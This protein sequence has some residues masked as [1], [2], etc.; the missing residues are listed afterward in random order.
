MEVIRPVRRSRTPSW[1]GVCMNLVLTAWIMN[2]VFY[3]FILLYT[4]YYPFREIWAAIPGVWLQQ[5]ARAALPSPTGACWVFLC[6]RNAPNSDVDYRIFNVRTWPFLCV[7]IHTRRGWAHRQRVD[8]TFLTEK[9]TNFSCA[10]DGVRTSGLW[11][12]SP[13]LYRLSH[14][15]HPIFGFCLHARPNVA[16]YCTLLCL[17]VSC[18]CL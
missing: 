11:I 14:P 7:R 2:N 6:F 5:A 8:T 18:V 12:S 1:V 3:L 16:S 10:A 4:L 9:L 13:T 15:C 17:G